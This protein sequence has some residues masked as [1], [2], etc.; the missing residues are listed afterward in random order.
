MNWENVAV[1]GAQW[2]KEEMRRASPL[3]GAARCK[4]GSN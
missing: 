3:G 1:R 4:G 2:H